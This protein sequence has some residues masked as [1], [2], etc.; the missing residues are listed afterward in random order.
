M[1]PHFDCFALALR[2]ACVSRPS[3]PINNTGELIIGRRALTRITFVLKEIINSIL[4]PPLPAPVFGRARFPVGRT[5]GRRLELIGRRA[6]LIW[7]TRTCRRVS[8]RG[9]LERRFISGKCAPFGQSGGQLVCLCALVAAAVTHH[10][11][12]SSTAWARLS[13]RTLVAVPSLTARMA[14]R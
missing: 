1:P 10:L 4:S 6:A 14:A 12:R 9:Q 7:H 13:A 11:R 8:G 3:D 2:R 5:P